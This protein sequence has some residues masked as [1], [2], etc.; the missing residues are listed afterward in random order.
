[1]QQWLARSIV[2]VSLPPR[3]RGLKFFS[4]AP[5]CDILLVAPSAGAWIEILLC[6]C[7]HGFHLVAPSAGAWIEILAKNSLRRQMIGS[8][9]PRERGLKYVVSILY[10]LKS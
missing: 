2:H 6:L 3:E 8:L 9:P 1:M 5:M 4:P 7:L 10:V